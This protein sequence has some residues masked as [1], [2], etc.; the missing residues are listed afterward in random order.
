[1]RWAPQTVLTVSGATVALITLFASWALVSPM[2]SSADEDFHL[3]S[4][5][6]ADEPSNNCM[7]VAGSDS[8][9]FL[10]PAAIGSE[11]CYLRGYL[12][13]SKSS[14]ACLTNTQGDD[15][16]MATHRANNVAGYYPP[17]FYQ[18]MN[19]FVQS[20]AAVAVRLMRTFNGTLAAGLLIFLLI[21]T[22]SWLARP[23]SLALLVALVPFGLFFI[24]SINPSSWA[25]LGVFSFWAFFLAWLT[26][27][28]PLSRGG[29]MRLVGL[30]LAGALVVSSR[31]D[32]ALYAGLTTAVAILVAWP[33]IRVHTKRLW[34]LAIPVPFLLWALA[35]RFNSLAGLVSFAPSTQT[36]ASGMSA[37]AA[38]VGDLIRNAMEIP[39]FLAGALGAN[40][41]DFDQSSA[42]LYGIGSVDIRMPSI[43][44]LITVGMVSAVLFL[45]LR[46]LSKRR[47]LGIVILIAALTLV[48]LM[49]TS[50]FSYQYSYAPRTIYPLLLAS[51]AIALM[52]FPWK[53]L[54]LSKVQVNLLAAGFSVANAVALLTTVRRY[55]N[56]QSETWLS[57]FFTPEWWWDF[58]PSPQVV[59]MIGSLAGVG[60]A[61]GLARIVYNPNPGARFG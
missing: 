32:A 12:E 44:P 45:S 23:L 40:A 46:T 52:V 41:P 31:S 28:R 30:G 34:V 9:L 22:Q 16:Y 15:E 8:N 11:T 54:T 21:T 47:A 33:K 14:A 49:A 43:L 37:V 24:P 58:G 5:W 53:K 60:V 2:G 27:D 29:L 6:C 51:I 59:V 56:G 1:M 7:A 19:F 57:F 25:I 35:F 39:A 36:D 38:V 3:G 20:D 4:I 10:V 18:T 55:T 48:P 17:P 26:S 42:F 50:R 61:I 13:A